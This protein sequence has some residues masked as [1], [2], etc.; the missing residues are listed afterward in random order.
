MAV[1]TRVNVLTVN[2]GSSSLKL[3]LV[4]DGR[5]EREYADLDAALA[6]PAPDA[7]GHR[8]VHGGPRTSPAV[9]D[10]RVR[11]ELGALVDL[12][13]LQQPPSLAALDAC[14]SAWSGVSQVACF[15]TA[16]H[17]TIPPAAS[18]Y[19]LP[20]AWRAAGVRVYGFHGLSVAW[21]AS[22]LPML[23]PGARRVLVAH[24]GSGS[25]LTA[26]VDGRSVATTMG[27]TPS[28]GLVMGTRSGSVDPLA[29]LWLAQSGGLGVDELA[30][31]L[32][33]SSGLLGLA[34]TADF[35]ELMRRADDPADDRAVLALGV[36]WH[37]LVVLAGGM[38]AAMGGV[39]AVVLTG[40]IGEHAEAV[41]VG[42][43]ERLGWLGV[44]GAVPLVVTPA[45]EDLQLASEVEGLLGRE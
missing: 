30:D 15:D 7:V 8:V 37:R 21:V 40:G 18:T 35:A 17:A 34:G 38:V 39:D 13:P 32:E 25:S 12:A 23:A 28:D 45:R 29:V 26:V 2:A 33:R 9:V 31:G 19:A 14:R 5:V 41:R 1:G 6:G 43:A 27:F 20:A 16:F 22:R 36:W 42:L 11:R 24:L 3:A 44:G 10:D 4:V